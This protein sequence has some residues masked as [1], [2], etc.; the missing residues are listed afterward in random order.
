[1]ALILSTNWNQENFYHERTDEGKPLEIISRAPFTN[2]LKSLRDDLVD[3]QNW[4]LQQDA[5]TI[6]IQLKTDSLAKVERGCRFYRQREILSLT[7]WYYRDFNR[8]LKWQE[9]NS[10]IKTADRRKPW[11]PIIGRLAACPAPKRVRPKGMKPCEA[12]SAGSMSSSGN[13]VALICC[14]SCAGSADFW[15]YHAYQAKL[16]RRNFQEKRENRKKHADLSKKNKM[17]RATQAFIVKYIME[18]KSTNRRTC[19]MT[20]NWMLLG[21][22]QFRKMLNQPPAPVT[23]DPLKA[24]PILYP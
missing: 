13:T 16:W 20:R 1:M 10:A 18:Q 17:F 3:G 8:W 24:V 6:P 9:G 5:M 11:T 23:H 19:S 2:R 15:E 21:C 7:S 4:T 12:M 22:Q 14:R